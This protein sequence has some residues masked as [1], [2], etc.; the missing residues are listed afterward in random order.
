MIIEINDNN[1]PMIQSIAHVSQEVAFEIMSK[2]GNKTR[3]NAGKRMASAKNR[4]HWLQRPSKKG[5]MLVPYRSKDT[6][7]LGQRTSRTGSVDNP[8][9]MANMISSNLMEESGTL[10][11]GGRNKKKTV[12]FR[13][14]GVRTGTGTLSAI[15][16]HTQ[17]II[18]KLDK[19]ERNQY[20]GWGS[21]GAKKESMKGFRNAKYRRTDFMTKGFGDSIPYMRQE[22]TSGYETTIGRAV[23]KV[24]V[25]LKP[26]RRVVS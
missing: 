4:H 26:S 16:K 6:K 3:K 23:N 14:D 21:S 12:I 9:S 2:I 19:G 11:V 17:S 22:L 15:S 18:H 5:S 8:A 10:V 25:K 7:E 24:T 1:T 20:H 13:K